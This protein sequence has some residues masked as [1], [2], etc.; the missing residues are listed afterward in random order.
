MTLYEAEICCLLQKYIH[1]LQL[2]KKKRE[3]TVIFNE[4]SEQFDDLLVYRNFTSGRIIVFEN[5]KFS[6][7]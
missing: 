6:L 7:L 1:I 3:F 5:F 2:H 4:F